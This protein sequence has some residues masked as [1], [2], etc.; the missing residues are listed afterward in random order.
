MIISA[1]DLL[2]TRTIPELRNL[3]GSLAVD[4]ESKQTE[5]RLMVGSKYHDF[6]QSADT[7]ASMYS[8]SHEIWSRLTKFSTFSIKLIEHAKELLK[9]TEPSQSQISRTNIFFGTPFTDI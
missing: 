7:I 5:L 1:D 3:V 6:I 8:K 9:H 2:K 4:G